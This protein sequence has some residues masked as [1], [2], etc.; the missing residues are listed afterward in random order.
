MNIYILEDN[1]IQQCLLER[2]VREN[3]KKLLISVKNILAT[4]KPD[5]LLSESKTSSNN[6]Y[7]LDIEIM[8][9]GT[10]GLEV[11]KEIRKYDPYGQIVFITTH[12]N[13]L[14]VTFV[15]KV[16]ALDFIAKE[17]ALDEIEAKI[18]ECLIIANERK[19]IS[20][21]EDWFVFENKFTKFQVPFSSIYYFETTDVP[22]KIRLVSENRNLEFYGELKD[23]E[24]KDSRLFRCHRAFVVNLINVE[25]INK[26]KKEIIFQNSRK[27]GG[28]QRMIPASRQLLKT[29]LEKIGQTNTEG[30]TSAGNRHPS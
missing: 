28:G 12:S 22:H 26:R 13:M 8:G 14:P 4:S 19:S 3:C 9:C 18:V 20:G 16:S 10:R 1:L 17:D 5:L 7:F 2:V 24:A 23:I 21:G 27:T 15:Y 30:N 29:L 6:L 25:Y 11:A